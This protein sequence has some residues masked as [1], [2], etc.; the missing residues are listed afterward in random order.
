MEQLYMFV[1]VFVLSTN[2]MII[3]VQPIL[4][5]SYFS[6][7]LLVLIYLVRLFTNPGHLLFFHTFGRYIK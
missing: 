4:W 1:S 3:K 2:S 6:L 7:V 5:V